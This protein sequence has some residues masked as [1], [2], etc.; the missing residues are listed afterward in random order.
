MIT[1]KQAWMK[2]K[3]AR[4]SHRAHLPM[5]PDP[6][7]AAPSDPLQ[8]KVVRFSSVVRCVLIPTRK[9]IPVKDC[10]WSHEDY[11]VNLSSAHESSSTEKTA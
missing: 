4:R 5:D 8:P 1:H 11:L 2:C 7:G 10:W 6:S 3:C 9:E